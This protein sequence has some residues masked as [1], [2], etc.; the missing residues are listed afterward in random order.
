MGEGEENGRAA[1]STGPMSRRFILHC[2]NEYARM[3]ATGQLSTA[4]Y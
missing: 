3:I 1:V 2:L 4:F